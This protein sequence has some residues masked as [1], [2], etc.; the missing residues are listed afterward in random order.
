LTAAVTDVLHTATRDVSYPEGARVEQLIDIFT[1]SLHCSSRTYERRFERKEL[2][3][4]GRWEIIEPYYHDEWTFTNVVHT[5]IG[6]EKGEQL[7][8]ETASFLAHATAPHLRPY[9][10]L[11]VDIAD[12]NDLRAE[13]EN[14]FPPDFRDTIFFRRAKSLTHHIRCDVGN[15]P[16]SPSQVTCLLS[17]EGLP[18]YFPALTQSEMKQYAHRMYTMLQPGGYALFFP[19]MTEGNGHANPETLIGAI[20][21]WNRRGAEVT[22]VVYTKEELMTQ[23]RDREKRLTERSPVFAEKTDTFTLLTVHKPSFKNP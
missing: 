16:V 2:V 5:L 14:S 22:R 21:T 19:W 15:L 10:V 18:Y 8:T 3:G 9:T 13:A 7:V 20:K 6:A 12:P 17:I 4:R 11:T 1:E 23:M